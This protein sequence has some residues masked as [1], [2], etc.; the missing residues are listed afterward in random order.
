MYYSY[1]KVNS[2]SALHDFRDDYVVPEN[3]TEEQFSELNEMHLA[4]HYLG[5]VDNVHYYFVPDSYPLV[6][7][8]PEINAQQ[9]TNLSDSVK[10]ELLIN[11]HYANQLRL[12]RG[13]KAHKFISDYRYDIDFAFLYNLIIDLA[14]VVQDLTTRSYATFTRSND[15]VDPKVLDNLSKLIDQ[16][17]DMQD[18]L[19]KA[20]L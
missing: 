19:N 10:E 18:K 3:A 13:I 7:Q 2:D 11:G 5:E 17:K 9:L 8:D 14:T 12:I 6:E 20:G 1:N 4:S 16:A 15:A